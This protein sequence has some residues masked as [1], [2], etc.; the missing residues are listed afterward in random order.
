MKT[1]YPKEGEQHDFHQILQGA[2]V[3]RPVAFVSS[4]DQSGNVNLSP[5]SYFNM[6]GTNPP[7]LIFSP[8]IRT[9]DLS[10]KDTLV[11][12]LEVPEVVIH[13][14]PHG[15]V[16]QMSL[17][18]SPYE[19]EVNEFEKAGLTSVK[20][21]HVT[22]PRVKEAPVA[23]E[24]KVIEVKPLG[25][26]GGA[27]NL[28]ICEVLV[29][30]ISEWIL[31]DFGS[32]DP[33]KL[34]AVARMGGDWYCRASGKSLFQISK[35]LRSKGI[36]VDSIPDEIRSSLVLTGNNLGRL[37]NVEKLPTEQE[38]ADYGEKEEIQEMKIR[39][40]N[41]LDSLLDHLH[42]A[43]KEALEEGDVTEAWLILLQK[44]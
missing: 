37:G 5:F 33:R 4:I 36:G 25:T 13:I 40:K 23:F 17:S 30:H 16:E 14:V 21:L 1:I 7:I 15:M 10:A 24:C 2:I 31:D 26:S 18:S 43:A 27:G 19:R 38:I 3:P 11:N 44:R 29:A 42:L 41:D 34:D 20:S 6:F 12:V 9:G 22:P 28:V 35:P 39:F 32:I 8:T